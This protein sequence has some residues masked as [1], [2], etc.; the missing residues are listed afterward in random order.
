MKRRSGAT[1]S[2]TAGRGN[3]YRCGRRAGER[4]E[5]P[6]GVGPELVAALVGLAVEHAVRRGFV[7]N[8]LIQISGRLLT[9]MSRICCDLKPVRARYQSAK[10]GESLLPKIALTALP[11]TSSSRRRWCAAQ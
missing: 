1:C 7:G 10:R 3:T 6:V 8:R 11:P 4:N 5:R 9:G 2:A